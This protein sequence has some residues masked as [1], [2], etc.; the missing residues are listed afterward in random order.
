MKVSEISDGETGRTCKGGFPLADRSID[1][2]LQSDF[3]A[4]NG[5][6]VFECGLHNMIILSNGVRNASGKRDRGS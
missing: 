1:N 4:R 5:R 6:S 2:P 3:G